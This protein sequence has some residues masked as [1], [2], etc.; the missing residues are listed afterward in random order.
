MIVMTLYISTYTK[1]VLIFSKPLPFFCQFKKIYIYI[2]GTVSDSCVS[3]CCSC[4][5]SSCVNKSCC[6]V[7]TDYQ[8]NCNVFVK[9]ILYIGIVIT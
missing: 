8:L 3:D 7:W 2:G 9:S 5:A 4:D 6:I 1:K